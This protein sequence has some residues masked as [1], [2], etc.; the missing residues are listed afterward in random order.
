MS[1][2]FVYT[3]TVEAL[4]LVINVKERTTFTDRA[5]RKLVSLYFAYRLSESLL[6]DVMIENPCTFQRRRRGCD[7]QRNYLWWV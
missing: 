4:V 6:F 5:G 7:R 1:A 3:E 2:G